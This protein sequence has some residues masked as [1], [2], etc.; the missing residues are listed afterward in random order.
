MNNKTKN[1]QSASKPLSTIVYEEGST[2]IPQ[3]STWLNSLGKGR[4]YSKISKNLK[5]IY[6]IINTKTNKFYIGSSSNIKV[7]L[8]DHFTR[9]RTNKHTNQHLQNS[10]N[11]DT[12]ENFDFDILEVTENLRNIEKIY[13]E[14]CFNN[15]KNLLF[16]KT[17]MVAGSAGFNFTDLEKLKM[18][19]SRKGIP[20]TEDFKR[21]LRT[22]ILQYDIYGNF[23][24]EH[25]GIREAAKTVN[26]NHR[27][28][29]YSCN[30][31]NITAKGFVWRYKINNEIPLKIVVRENKKKNS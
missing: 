21:Q 3:G 28:I 1:G 4:D 27:T 26:C 10:F 16:N 15:Y 30:E 20:K 19:K 5:G 17:K 18:S 6:I 13:L 24:R 2:T 29:Q 12:I 7:R 22:P 23:I 8:H 14:F 31:K 25:L 11:T 9:L